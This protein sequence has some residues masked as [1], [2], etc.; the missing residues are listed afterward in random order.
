MENPKKTL[1]L[2]AR[3][4]EQIMKLNKQW[5]YHIQKMQ[6]TFDINDEQKGKNILEKLNTLVSDKC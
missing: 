2:A 3:I 1:A 6:V 5:F 4:V